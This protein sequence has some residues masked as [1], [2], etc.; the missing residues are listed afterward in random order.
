MKLN[1]V[2]ENTNILEKNSFFKVLELNIDQNKS[3]DVEEIISDNRRELKNIDNENIAKVFEIV[4]TDF[5][6]NIQATLASSLS[7][8][9]ILIDIIIKDGNCIL[10]RDWFY[11]LYEKAIAELTS[12]VA[13][14]NTQVEEES[15]EI[16]T[17]RI[18]DYK[19]YKEAIKV[20]YYNDGENNSD[21][22]VTSDEY[23]I[24]KA[25]SNGLGLSNEEIRLI[26][27]TILPIEKKDIDTLIKDL[28][29][30]GI[31]FYSKKNYTCYIPDETVRILRE[32]RGKNIADKYLRRILLSQKDAIINL[33]ARRYNIDYKL[34]KKAKISK[35]IGSGINI[36]DLLGNAIFKDDITLS[37]RKKEINSIMEANNIPTK[38][39]TIGDKVDAII[40][41]FTLIEKDE[42]VSISNDGYNLLV[43][44][45]YENLPESN[46]LLKE[47]F[48][49]QQDVVLDYELL[50][51]YNIKPLDILELIDLN[52]LKQ[53]CEI[54]EIKT[55]GDIIQNILDSYTN[56][57]NL[58]IENFIHIGNRDLNELKSNNLEIPTSEF[59]IKYEEITKKMFT[60]LGFHVD[61]ELKNKINTTKD[62]IDIL[63][64]LGNNEV[65]IVECKTVKSKTFN[66][67][68]SVSRQIKSYHDTA[69]KQGYRVNKTLLV[70][71]DFSEDFIYECELQYD[72]NL[73][74]ISSE[75]MY[76]IWEG[77]KEAKQKVFPVNLLMRD[78]IIDDNKILK[79]LKIR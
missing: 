18:R 47:E 45:L 21:F 26:N 73:S 17:H 35:L 71:P 42:R 77:F 28:K 10:S 40:D 63:I 76:H 49:L 64:N 62:K 70:A 29:E 1:K 69:T 75:V 56:S 6:K 7:Q 52:E 79:A 58:L 9:D 23:S 44:D 13:L 24:L 67:F 31:L 43:K 36:Y 14:F 53:F 15:K 4:K 33:V 46:Q 8:T 60:D 50:L 78:V 34:D 65:I 48:E 2:L 55:R 61:D 25:V 57:E 37:N 5:K 38:G 27:Y 66:K 20:A 39:N 3:G 19:I 41:Y 30:L 59:G 11:S 54:K 74:L 12:N 72:L 16:D 68:S 22:K 51:D 32:L